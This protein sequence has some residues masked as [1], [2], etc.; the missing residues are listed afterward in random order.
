MDGERVESDDPV[1]YSGAR[2]GP[3]EGASRVVRGGSWNNDNP[4]NF[5]CANRNNN[6][7]DNRND[8]N[9]FR[10]ASTVPCRNRV[11][12]GERERAGRV[13]TGSRPCRLS[14]GQI[15]KRG[16]ATGSRAATAAPRRG[17]VA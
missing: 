4:D 6:H 1:W 8:N 17:A 15:P 10:V 3:V 9:G 7:P 16:G 2:W 11:V 13:Q 12:H 14:Q 5:R